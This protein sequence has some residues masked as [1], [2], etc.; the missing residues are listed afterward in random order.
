MRDY[1]RVIEQQVH[2]LVDAIDTTIKLR[3]VGL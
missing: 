2:G 1:A 3:E